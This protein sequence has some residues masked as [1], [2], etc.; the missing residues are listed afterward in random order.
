MNQEN[1]GNIPPEY[2]NA[3]NQETKDLNPLEKKDFYKNVGLEL[4]HKEIYKEDT[5]LPELKNFRQEYFAEK[6]KDFRLENVESDGVEDALIQKILDEYAEAAV[7]EMS[8]KNPNRS[9]E[10]SKGVVIYKASEFL[11][12]DLRE[13][14]YEKKAD[15]VIHHVNPED[16]SLDAHVNFVMSVE[17]YKKLSGKPFETGEGKFP[18]LGTLFASDKKHYLRISE[19]TPG[20]FRDKDLQEIIKQKWELT[21]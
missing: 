11:I 8:F 5:Y 20:F 10:V 16:F 17:G 19:V 3:Q 2:L 7:I 1:Q 6:A 12:E 15:R 21:E 14:I 4:I 13:S 9:R 18:V